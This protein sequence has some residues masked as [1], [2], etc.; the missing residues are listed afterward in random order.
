MA[1][2]S[3]YRATNRVAALAS[4]KASRITEPV[5]KTIGASEAKIAQFRSMFPSGSA[6]LSAGNLQSLGLSQTGLAGRLMTSSQLAQFNNEMSQ[7]L[8]Q[9]AQQMGDIK[10]M[11]FDTMKSKF[12]E[13]AQTAKNAIS[14]SFIGKFL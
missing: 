5:L 9:M 8:H 4:M 7:S 1:N 11:A 13:K 2:D 14:N 12:I 3:A 6:P 10:E